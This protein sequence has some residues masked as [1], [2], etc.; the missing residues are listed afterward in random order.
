MN[1]SW[2]GEDIQNEQQLVWRTGE[3]HFQPSPTVS[4]LTIR[5]DPLLPRDVLMASFLDALASLGLGPVI[6]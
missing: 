5:G 3:D 1:T 2:C 6:K 4:Q